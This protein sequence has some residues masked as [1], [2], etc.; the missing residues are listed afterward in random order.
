LQNCSGN[1]NAR[2]FGISHRAVS[3]FFVSGNGLCDTVDGRD[4]P[5]V[6]QRTAE[7]RRVAQRIDTKLCSS[8]LLVSWPIHF[9]AFSV[10]SGEG[11]CVTDSGLKIIGNE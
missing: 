8:A 6:T 1:Q 7:F 3:D 11:L 5:G 10:R 2:L 4:S 9:K